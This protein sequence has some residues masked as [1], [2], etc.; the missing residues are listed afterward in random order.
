MRA[1]TGPSLQVVSPGGQQGF[2]Y[3]GMLV[4]VVIMGLMLSAVGR[5]WR[6][7]EQREREIQLLYIGHAYR[8]AI[9]SFYALGHRYPL[10]LQE[11]VID[12]RF[13]IPK[14]HLRRLYADPL[15][16]KADWSLVMT[17]NGQGIM[18]VASTSQAVPIKR[19][20]FDTIDQAFKDADCYCSWEFVY[21]AN[22][23][24]QGVAPG[25][26]TLPPGGVPTL[27]PGTNP[28]TPGG[29]S[30]A[31]GVPVPVNPVPTPPSGQ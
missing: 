7:T 22:R 26:T 4:A 5:V 30:G 20:G 23:W 12:E 11:L 25:G 9:A 16:G 6:T 3:I 10:T 24:T 14:H 1:R 18:G 31:P 2:T 19:D 29:P 27:D 8:M 28:W 13:P 17:P 21:H 15:T